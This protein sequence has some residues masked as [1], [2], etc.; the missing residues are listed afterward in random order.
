MLKK[1]NEFINEK[2]SDSEVT[3][4]DVKVIKHFNSISF[5]V[6]YKITIKTAEKLQY[7]CGYPRDTFGFHSYMVK[8]D[9]TYWS[10]FTE[11]II[12]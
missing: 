3:K 2:Y 5:I 9:K 8:Y 12:D 4:M 11:P 1:Y 10:C 6:P 7:E